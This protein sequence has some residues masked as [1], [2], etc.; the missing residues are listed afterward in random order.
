MI[1]HIKCVPYYYLKR[2]E[3]RGLKIILIIIH[4]SV[5]KKKLKGLSIKKSSDTTGKMASLQSDHQ[6]QGKTDYR[7]VIVRSKDDRKVFMNPSKN[8]KMIKNSTFRDH[9][10][11]D[12]DDIE[13]RRNGRSLKFKINS[14]S[15]ITV[16]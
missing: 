2:R 16:T 5:N 15:N 1:R 6:I 3:N 13:V 10:I 11:N 12:S 14:D 7:I 9:I 8:L 4:N